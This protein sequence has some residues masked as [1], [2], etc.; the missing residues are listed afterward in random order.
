MDAESLLDDVMSLIAD[1]L[2]RF[3]PVYD[4]DPKP[5]HRLEASMIA[6]HRLA[7]ETSPRPQPADLAD[8]EV[9]KKLARAA[10]AMEPRELY[11]LAEEEAPPEEQLLHDVANVALE[12][13]A[14]C[15]RRLQGSDAVGGI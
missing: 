4:V 1:L 15:G 5:A 14:E 9:V 7:R 6:F 2:R 13:L 10:A 12:A 11:V 8:D 3:A